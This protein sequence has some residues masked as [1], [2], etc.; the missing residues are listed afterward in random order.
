[1][2]EVVSA[3]ANSQTLPV[4]AVTDQAINVCVGDLDEM[5]ILLKSLL[6]GSSAVHFEGINDHKKGIEIGKHWENIILQLCD[7]HFY[8]EVFS[9]HQ[10]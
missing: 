4:D 5:L 2:D 3:S 8:A 9:E 7:E 6:D 1:M 10:N